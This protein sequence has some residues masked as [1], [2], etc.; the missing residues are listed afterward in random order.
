[1]DYGVGNLYSLKCSLG[2]VGFNVVI[3]ASESQIKAADAIILPGVGDFSTASKNLATI[4]EAVVEQVADGKPIFGVC[5]GMQLLFQRS[6]EGAGE[7]LKLLEGENVRLPKVVKV[8]HMGWNTVRI[9]RE[10]EL[11]E[12]LHDNEYYYFAHSYYPVPVDK[13]VICS[14]TEYGVIFPSIIVK[15]NIYGTQFHPEKSGEKGIRLLENFRN[16]VVR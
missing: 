2:K 6:E 16:F 3:G 11:F 12:D 1:M 13:N 15:S 10:N 8:P 9:V 5:L 14:E 4:K 7:G